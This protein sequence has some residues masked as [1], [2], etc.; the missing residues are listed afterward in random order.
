M[1]KG[2]SEPPEWI[3]LCLK[4]HLWVVDLVSTEIACVCWSQELAAKLWRDVY[5][6]CLAV[7]E[8]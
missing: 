2:E 4:V 3:V 6:N 5:L 1:S 8:D 7:A